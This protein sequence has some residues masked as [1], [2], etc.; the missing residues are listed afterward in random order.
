MTRVLKVWLRS[1]FYGN[2][3]LILT[4]T[5]NFLFR[6]IGTDGIYSEAI[7]ILGSDYEYEET[8]EKNPE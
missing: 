6:E 5:K 1:E 3:N 2:G 8:D 7:D 4:D